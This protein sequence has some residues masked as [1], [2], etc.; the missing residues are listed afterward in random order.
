[1][2]L[3][4][5]ALT[6][7]DMGWCVYPAHSVDLATGMCSCGRRD[8]PGPGKHPVGRWTEYQHRLPTKREVK[9]WF[10]GTGWNIGTVTGQISGI[11]VV[12][13]DGET[14]LA[15]V[16]A[17]NPSLEPTLTARTGGG[18]YHYYYSISGPTPSRVRAM[19]GVDI[20]GDGGY[21][22]L[23][24]S[25]HRSGNN[26][27]WLDPRE[28]AAFNPALFEKPEPVYKLGA[29]TG[30]VDE[31]LQGVTE[32]GRNAC[33]ARLA[34]RYFGLGL[35]REEVW[36][37]MSWWNSHND[38]PLPTSELKYAVDRIQR[39]HEQE[40]IPV[41]IQTLGQIREILEGSANER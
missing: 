16:Q 12:D 35:K 39:K 18:G 19:D 37:L 40:S 6:Y 15:S 34:G 22:V 32:G 24:P 5:E 7:L 26:Y 25:L 29:G 9:L 2:E 36:I 17:L 20:R 1:M 8:C 41:Q 31:V 38:P 11:A 23:P 28:L 14:G 33:A 21:V 4:R 13:V 27:T 3:L 30:W 10:K